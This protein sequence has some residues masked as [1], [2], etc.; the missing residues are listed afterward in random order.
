MT[1]L[2]SLRGLQGGDRT[3]IGNPSF[4]QKWPM[5][6]PRVWWSDKNGRD[7][8]VNLLMLGKLPNITPKEIHLIST[9]TAIRM[10]TPP[11]FVYKQ[12]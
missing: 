5:F 12:L 7:H 9:C 3:G 10:K 1:P 8:V 2:S 6:L 11:V 4:S